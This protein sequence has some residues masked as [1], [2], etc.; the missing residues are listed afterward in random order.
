M[1]TIYAVINGVNKVHTMRS[2]V[3]LSAHLA[4]TLFVH[5]ASQVHTLLI[6]QLAPFPSVQVGRKTQHLQPYLR[7]LFSTFNGVH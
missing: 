7:T 2:E 3:L 4:C 5:F 6:L 1:D